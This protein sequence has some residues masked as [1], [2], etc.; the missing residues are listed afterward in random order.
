MALSL[1]T[2]EFKHTSSI[3]LK[4]P[5][6]V[7]CCLIEYLDLDTLKTASLVSRDF[8]HEADKYLWKSFRIY[9]YY[10]NE[11]DDSGFIKER[12]RFACSRATCIRNFE[13]KVAIHGWRLPENETREHC[14][15]RLRDAESA[16]VDLKG[17]LNEFLLSQKH[18]TTLR[19]SSDSLIHQVDKDALP[20]LKHLRV[21]HTHQSVIAI[22]R[23]VTHLCVDEKLSH[24]DVLFSNISQSSLPLQLLWCRTT[25]MEDSPFISQESSPSLAAGA[26][27]HVRCLVLQCVTISMPRAGIRAL[28]V[29]SNLEELVWEIEAYPNLLQAFVASEDAKRQA[30]SD[31][32]R[33]CSN[34]CVRLR[35][36]TFFYA[37]T[38][39]S[40]V[41]CVRS[42]RSYRRE[43][44]GDVWELVEERDD[45]KWSLSSRKRLFPAVPC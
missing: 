15:I 32:F 41:H 26:L 16:E 43:R 4:F 20:R 35:K 17:C 2:L 1:Q 12:C 34:S 6:D 8:K 33:A 5:Y 23:P 14:A 42:S 19:L 29:L 10:Y 31:F 27:S 44:P 37:L 13:L 25:R 39:V 9:L 40:H 18:I 11:P 7:I 21:T 22:N 36:V 28:E 24:P 3:T 45:I 38:D 30:E